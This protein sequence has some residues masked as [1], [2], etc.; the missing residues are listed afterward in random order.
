[1]P[2]GCPPGSPSDGPSDSKS[3]VFGHGMGFTPI[4]TPQIKT[5]HCSLSY[6]PGGEFN[7]SGS[8]SATATAGTG[9]PVQLPSLSGGLDPG[10]ENWNSTYRTTDTSKYSLLEGLNVGCEAVEPIGHS[11]EDL[12]RMA[13]RELAQYTLKLQDDIK[14]MREDTASLRTD[15]DRMRV[16]IMGLRGMVWN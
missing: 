8:N 14:G 7:I 1:M 12:E 5:M 4:K 3:N 15:L 2:P 16:E 9:G 13:H 11:K 10:I 6:T